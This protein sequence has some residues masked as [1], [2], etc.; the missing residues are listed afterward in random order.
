MK[1]LLIVVVLGIV[2]IGFFAVVALPVAASVGGGTYAEVQDG[3]ADLVHVSDDDDGDDDGDDDHGA[4]SHPK[5]EDHTTDVKN[6]RH[7]ERDRE[8]RDDD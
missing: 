7:D 6:T 4:K 2:G 8:C 3:A 1:K 5:N